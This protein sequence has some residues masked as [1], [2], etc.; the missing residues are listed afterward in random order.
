MH[1][2]QRCLTPS[3]PHHSLDIQPHCSITSHYRCSH[4]I[5]SQRSALTLNSFYRI[6]PNPHLILSLQHS[7][8]LILLRCTGSLPLTS[9][10]R[11]SP[12]VTSFYRCSCFLTSHYRCISPLIAYCCCSP[13]L[14]SHY[15]IN[16]RL[17]SHHC[18]SPL[19]TSLHQKAVAMHMS[20][21]IL[22]SVSLHI[23]CKGC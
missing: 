12:P 18:C 23:A 10:H 2:D 19:L 11:I 15:G 16:P 5:P 4:L 17:I 1:P 20:C 6:S 7:P 9:F 3:R 14:T 13:C 8:H 22:R 21:Q